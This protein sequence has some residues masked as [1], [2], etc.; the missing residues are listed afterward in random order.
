MAISCVFLPMALLV[1]S[2]CGVKTDLEVIAIDFIRCPV[3]CTLKDMPVFV[4]A[5]GIVFWLLRLW[6][7]LTRHARNI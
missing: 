1:L 2:H 5:S 3:A 7:C 6:P 4:L